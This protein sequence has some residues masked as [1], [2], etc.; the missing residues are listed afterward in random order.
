MICLI[1]WGRDLKYQNLLLMDN[2][3]KIMCLLLICIV[4]AIVAAIWTISDNIKNKKLTNQLR[5]A[6]SE[7]EQIAFFDSLTGIFNKEHFLRA[8]EQMLNEK[9]NIKFVIITVDIERFKVINERFGTKIGDTILKTIA[10]YF[11][12]TIKSRGTYGRMESD[13]F[14]ACFPY[15]ELDPETIIQQLQSEFKKH[16]L[17]YKIDIFLGAYVVDDNISV[18]QMCDRAYMALATVKGS[19]LTKYAV[20]NDNLRQTMLFEQQLMNDIPSALINSE[21][22]VYY[23]PLYSTKSEKPVCAEALIRW[24]HPQK[25]MIP[26]DKFV[27]FCEKNGLITKLD[28]FVATQVCIMIQKRKEEG[29]F[30]VPISINLSRANFFTYKIVSKIDKITNKYKVTPKDIRIEITESV[31]SDNP[32]QVLEIIKI[33]RN[34]GYRILMDDFGSGYS[35]LN[36]LKNL[37][38]DILKIDKKLVDDIESSDRA[39][40]V[41]ISIVRMAKWLNMEVIAEG[42]ET[43]KQFT[44]L[45]KAE[46][47]IIQGYFF[48]KPLSERDFI[49]KIENDNSLDIII[50]EDEMD[51]I[52]EE[53]K[54]KLLEDENNY[55]LK[56]QHE[57]ENSMFS[58]KN[59]I[60]SLPVGIGIFELNEMIIPKFASR[61]M[62][63]IFGYDYEEYL[64]K[65]K[66]NESINYSISANIIKDAM[67]TIKEN[68]N[69][70]REVPAKR[71][72]GKSIFVNVMGRYEN[73]DEGKKI[74]YISI[75]DIT[76]QKNA[77]DKIKMQE[78]R[79]KILIESMN[80]VVFDYNPDNDIFTYTRRGTNGGLEEIVTAN[81]IQ[82]IRQTSVIHP[83]DIDSYIFKIGSVSMKPSA[84][85]FECRIRRYQKEFRWCVANYISI[86]DKQGHV[87][88][89]VGRVDDI[90]KEKDLFFKIKQEEEYRNHCSNSSL[91]FVYEFNLIN[92][93]FTVSYV[94]DKAKKQFLPF[95]K[96]IF[97]EDTIENV[98]PDDRC[99]IDEAYSSQGLRNVVVSGKHEVIL[100]YRIL[101]KDGRWNWIETA[102][103]LI[104]DLE[105]QIKFIGYITDINDIKMLE[106]RA[107]LDGVCGVLNRFAS[108]RMMK[109]I[110]E[111][112]KE[113]QYYLFICDI[114]NFKDINDTYG[115]MEGDNIL[116][117]IGNILKN[118]FTDQSVIGRLGGD[119]FFVLMYEETE[120]EKVKSIAENMLKDVGKIIIKGSHTGK[121][122][123]SIGISSSEYEGKNFKKLYNVADEALY[124]AKK[125]GKN[126]YYF[127]HNAL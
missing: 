87:Y 122:S 75:T 37:P 31:Y 26:P 49:E 10:L 17:P 16:K 59:M 32:G 54:I 39:S 65:I 44:F 12:N 46:C 38:V 124:R 8:T 66:N 55:L 69:F 80:T 95:R 40:S 27:P 82:N 71:K 91:L 97:T 45:K 119:E 106:E 21:F 127:I 29:K 96:Y 67:K 78:E 30:I 90:Q 41:L 48:S 11:K 79:Y 33:M 123:I 109:D 86:A 107:Q 68:I 20:Y 74:A 104:R 13:H 7:L 36:V 111:A 92:D 126:R 113:K 100:R 94:S 98:H 61:K 112:N 47:D 63:E 116:R 115:H 70:S 62:C 56:Q 57:Q 23:Q 72:D 102:I 125:A 88:R 14:A 6:K 85:K 15:A 60:G 43:K 76:D 121:I 73:Q 58:F 3:D 117:T 22:C 81:F 99:K 77:L 103:H 19:Y 114:D 84:G 1:K 51:I 34:K 120:D 52:D 42:V 101:K 5:K 93:N 25:G 110:I 118:N 83:E 9:S 18:L 24:K 53:Q 89:I 64:E 108:E 50:D 105:N 2:N 28:E 4:I 35:S